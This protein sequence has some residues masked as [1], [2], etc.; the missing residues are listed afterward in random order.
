[1]SASEHLTIVLHG[2]FNHYR[3]MVLVLPRTISLYVFDSFL[4][5]FTVEPIRIFPA[6]R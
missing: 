1:M 6:R 5:L 2:F 3:I 4:V